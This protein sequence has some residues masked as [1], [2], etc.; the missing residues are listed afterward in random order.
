MQKLSALTS[1]GRRLTRRADVSESTEGHREDSIAMSC[2]VVAACILFWG[3]VIAKETYFYYFAS[4]IGRG[5]HSPS[6][7]PDG[8]NFPVPSPDPRWGAYHG[9]RPRPNEDRRDEMTASKA[10]KLSPL[11]RSAKTSLPSSQDPTLKQIVSS[12]DT[13]SPITPKQRR[14]TKSPKT[15]SPSKNSA[16]KAVSYF[17]AG[18][19]RPH[20]GGT[21]LDTIISPDSPEVNDDKYLE[22]F[23]EMP[24]FSIMSHNYISLHREEVSR[25]RKQKWVF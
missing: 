22:T 6:P 9:P 3:V 19:L 4:D 13:S 23:L 17:S 10:K 21:S 18:T 16:S 24:W 12:L 5:S 7:I 1:E 2:S 15:R 20:S 14:S 25:D 11:F 8:Q